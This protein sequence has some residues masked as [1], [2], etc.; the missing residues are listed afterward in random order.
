MTYL[1]KK[2]NYIDASSQD[3]INLA[4]A[5]FLK[6]KCRVND[7]ISLPSYQKCQESYY[8]LYQNLIQK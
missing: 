6:K 4:M 1:E 2:A 3:S 5:E 7:R 8:Q